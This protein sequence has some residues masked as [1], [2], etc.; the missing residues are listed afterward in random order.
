MDGLADRALRGH[1]SRL[2][3]IEGRR[4]FVPGPR[5]ALGRAGGARAVMR[6]GLG[7]LSFQPRSMSRE[8]RLL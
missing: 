1:R 6:P 2:G 5:A 4:R 7:A 3:P 8:N